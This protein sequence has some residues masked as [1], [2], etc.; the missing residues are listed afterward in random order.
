MQDHPVFAG[1]KVDRNFGCFLH[2]YS[3]DE[4]QFAF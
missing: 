1:V 4:F 2:F 3:P